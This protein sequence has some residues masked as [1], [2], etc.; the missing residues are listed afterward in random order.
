MSVNLRYR[1]DALDEIKGVVGGG[2][3]IDTGATGRQ[4]LG[5]SQGIAGAK[6]SQ[7]GYQVQTGRAAPLDQALIS[8]EA[9]E[10]LESSNGNG[11][12]GGVSA[13][14]SALRQVT[15]GR[16]GERRVASTL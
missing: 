7:G 3:A 12:L 10:E 1:M 14:I 6:A 4:I 11:S 8:A 9:T 2:Q 16:L 13:I 5:F 15:D